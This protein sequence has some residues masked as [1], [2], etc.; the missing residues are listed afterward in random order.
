[1]FFSTASSNLPSNFNLRWERHDVSNHRK[2][3]VYLQ[4]CSG[5]KQKIRR[6]RI[7][8]PV[9]RESTGDRWIQI[10]KGQKCKKPGDRSW[11]TNVVPLV[12]VA[13]QSNLIT[14]GIKVSDRY[15]EDHTK[16]EVILVF[17]T[18]VII[19]LM[20]LD[21]LFV[22]YWYLSRYHSFLDR[23]RLVYQ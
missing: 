23:I 8:G 14:E 9:L 4:A 18:I 2:I 17:V 12:C 5:W 11:P 7:T 19:Q 1:M 13:Y 21:I 20:Q 3:T 16:W 22:R 10:I 15:S 6:S